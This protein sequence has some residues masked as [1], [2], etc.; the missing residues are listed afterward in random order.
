MSEPPFT[1]GVRQPDLAQASVAVVGLGLMGGSRAAALATRRACRRVVGVARRPAALDEA[2]RRGWI[3]A[4]ATDLA[5]GVAEADLVVLATPPRTILAQVAGIGPLLPAGAVLMDLGSTKAAIVEAMQGL[6]AWVHPL[7]G[8]PM[9]GKERAG[10]AA[11]DPN[12]F[13]GRPF[14]LTPLRRTPAEATALGQALAR[15]VG[16]CTML[17]EPAEHDRMVAWVSHLPHLAALAVV[18]AARAGA[19]RDPALWSLAAGGFRDTTRLAASDLTMMLDM[20]MTNRGPLLAAAR[21]F[22]AELAQLCALIECGDEPA[23]S[24]LLDEAIRQR[25]APNL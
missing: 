8:H 5:E 20:F 1:P 24:R 10:L 16:G 19:E 18:R 4:G 25:R 7:G 9:C 21:Q 2:L 22:Q 12:L 23:L 17:L 13:E 14:I 3:D 6:P 15:A 11:A